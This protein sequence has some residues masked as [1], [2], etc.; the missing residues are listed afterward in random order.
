MTQAPSYTIAKNSLGE[1][2][3]LGDR[4]GLNPAARSRISVD[5][6]KKDEELLA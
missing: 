6:P 3:A 1:L 2:R 5:T 4:L